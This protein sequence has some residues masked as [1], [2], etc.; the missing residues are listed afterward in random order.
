VN[1]GDLLLDAESYFFINNSINEIVKKIPDKN[2][3]I[4]DLKNVFCEKDFCKFYDNENYFFYDQ[5]HVGYF[6][7]K[8]IV[9]YIL[10]KNYFSY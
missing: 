9:R 10:N 2:F 5:S 6:G 1:R 4:I 3:N 7:A 8:K